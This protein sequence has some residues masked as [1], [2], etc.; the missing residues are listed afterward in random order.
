VTVLRQLLLIAKGVWLEAL[1]R[2]E[3]YVIV[4]VTCLFILALAQLRFF[5]LESLNKFYREVA[6]KIMGGAAG[7]T[8]IVLGARQLPREF[9]SRTIYPLLARP[10]NRSTFL[11]GKQLGVAGAGIFCLVLFL[12]LYILGCLTLG[13]ELYPWLLWQHFLLQMQMLL[14]LSSFCF[15]LSVLV[16]F[17]AAVTFGCL[18]FFVS[19]VFANLYLVLYENATEAGRLIIWAVTWLTP[20]LMMFDLSEK[21]IHG[22]VWAPLDGL[23]VAQLGVYASLFTMGHLLLTL[24]LFRRKAL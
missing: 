8:V 21:N 9:Q 5:G 18:Y 20:Q 19:S 16:N 6:L 10:I 12:S 23:A 15:L 13:T 17:D 14:V 3:I 2:K 24:W 11:L 1:R 7:L 22:D 4:A